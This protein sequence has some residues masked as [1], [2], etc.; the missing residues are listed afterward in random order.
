M[1]DYSLILKCQAQSIAR[2]IAIAGVVFLPVRYAQA[3]QVLYDEVSRPVGL[4]SNSRTVESSTEVTSSSAPLV[5][6]SYSFVEW[7]FG[8][9]RQEDLLGRALNPFSFTIYEPTT[10]TAVYALTSADTDADGVKDWYERHFYGDL[11]EAADSDTDGDGIPLSAEYS[12]DYHPNLANEVTGRG[13]AWQRSDT[14]FVQLNTDP[15]YVETSDPAG[16]VGEIQTAVSLNTNLTTRALYGNRGGY[17]FA[18]WTV[19]DVR[20]QDLLGRALDP[21]SLVVTGD[22]TAVAVHLPTSQD[23]DGD[24]VP[25]WYEFNYYGSTNLDAQ[26]DSDGD[27]IDLATEYARDYQPVVGNE[28]TGR[29]LAWQRSDTLNIIASS[30]YVFY[31]E[32]TDPEGLVPT[33]EEG[34]LTGTNLTTRALAGSRGGYQFTHWTLNGSRQDDLLGQALD[35]IS[36][37]V[38]GTT[39]AVAHH[40]PGDQDNDADGIPDWYEVRFSG[41]TNQTASADTDDD[42]VDLATEYARDYNP[43]IS[44]EITGRGLSWQRSDVQFVD[45]QMFERVRYV[46]TNQVLHGWFSSSPLVFEG[47]DLGGHTAPGVGDWDGD[48]DPDI[49]IG[50]SNGAIRVYENTG[51]R[52]TMDLSERTGAFTSLVGS[53]GN[54]GDAYP[55]LGDWNGDG[56]DDLAVGG[57]SGWVRIL[58]STERFLPSQNP[59]VDY[60]LTVN[61]TTSTVPAFAE[62]TGDGLVDLLVLLDDGSVRAYPHTGNASQPY[63]TASLVD[64]LLGTPVANGTGLAA[65]DLNHDGLVDILVSADDGRM[66]QFMSTSTGTYSLYSK[67]WAGTGLGF[68]QRLTIAAAD[69]DG[70]NDVDALCGYAQ[71]GIMYLRDPRIGIPYGLRAAGGPGSI[72]LDWDPNR[73]Y[74][75]K[76]Y[77]VYRASD[78]SGPFD[79]LTSERWPLNSYLDDAASAG[80]SW[81]YYVTAV[82]EA[83]YPGNTVAREVESRPSQTVSADTGRVVLWMPDYFGRAGENAVLQINVE[84]GTGI[85]GA[86]MDLRITYDP[87]L[88]TPRSQV[89]TNAT[90]ELTALTENLVISDNSD[91]ANGELLIT[92]SSGSVLGDGH[93]FDISF[94]VASNAVPGQVATNIFSSAALQSGGVPLNVDSSDK[95]LF[96]VTA[97]GYFF[98]DVN[99]DGVIDMDDHNHLM[100]LLKKN[101]RDPLPQEISAGDMNGNGQLDHKDIPLLLGL[102]H[103]Q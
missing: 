45:L 25:D 94:R 28:I 68:A 84:H 74:R 35:P 55:S 65:A 75:L 90:V 49:F 87:V 9:V 41:D 92:G 102:I 51:T 15:L 1:S 5:S 81:H 82:S 53:W 11:D 91:I 69:M 71:G 12:R 64:D 14:I 3:T 54:L 36:I 34:S 39:V 62:V 37:A 78:E 21:V 66:W 22:T 72:Q 10:A 61:G 59:D 6:G 103:E 18:Y 48:G 40:L 93:L 83:Y 79:N 98:G 80:V 76:G 20:Q 8:G 85:S 88:L 47:T 38:T 27:G 24:A 89:S 52:Y 97:T 17:S 31:T 95:A 2:G 43:A 33:I 32:K 46:M 4:I 23:N 100:W 63:I 13:L 101:T 99:G 29:G 58:S 73:S 57:N 96:T 19:N 77:Y 56:I 70:D 44:N 26:S 86:G 60:S 16:L 42:G 50:T 7:Q 67:V 30:N